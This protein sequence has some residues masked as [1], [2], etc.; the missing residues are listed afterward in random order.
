MFDRIIVSEDPTQQRGSPAIGAAGMLRNAQLL[1]ELGCQAE[2]RQLRIAQ[3][4][5]A[6]QRR[7][8]CV[9]GQ[10]KLRAEHVGEMKFDDLILGGAA[11]P[12]SVSAG[13]AQPQTEG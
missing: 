7:P 13:T 10:P 8:L 2:Y 1:F 6:R 9:H 11:D 3:F 12:R 4:D 5:L